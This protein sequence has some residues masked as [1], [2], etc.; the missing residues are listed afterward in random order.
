MRRRRGVKA[1][2]ARSKASTLCWASRPSST[3]PKI[4]EPIMVTN[5]GGR[6]F[7]SL[8]QHIFLRQQFKTRPRPVDSHSCTALRSAS[9]ASA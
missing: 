2:N 9:T 5:V 6:F 4:G 8:N 7:P 1:S 3:K